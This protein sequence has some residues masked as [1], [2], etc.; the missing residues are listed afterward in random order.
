MKQETKKIRK[1]HENWMMYPK[2]KFYC[3]SIKGHKTHVHTQKTRIKR[4]K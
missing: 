4:E 3:S 2:Q 1:Q